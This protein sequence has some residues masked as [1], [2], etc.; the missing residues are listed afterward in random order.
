MC[1]FGLG[2]IVLPVCRSPPCPLTQQASYFIPGSASFPDCG[3]PGTGDRVSDAQASQQV[4]GQLFLGL[5]FLDEEA[6]SCDHLV[7]LVPRVH[8]KDKAH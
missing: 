6:A 8:G 1:A 3:A 2:Q 4:R 5:I 7:E